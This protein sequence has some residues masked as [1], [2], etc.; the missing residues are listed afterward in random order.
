MATIRVPETSK[1]DNNQKSYGIFFTK[2][3]SDFY[4]ALLLEHFKLGTCLATKNCYKKCLDDPTLTIN[5]YSGRHCFQ[6]PNDRIL[7]DDIWIQFVKRDGWQSE[8]Y[9]DLGILSLV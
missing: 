9:D 5:C 4:F 6:F 3:K 2:K 7:S 8:K 1:S